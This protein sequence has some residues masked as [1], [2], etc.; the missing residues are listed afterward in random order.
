MWMLCGFC[1]TCPLAGEGDD[2][3][4]AAS[5]CSSIFVSESFAAKIPA[6]FARD[7]LKCNWEWSSIGT[8][9][10][11]A[12]RFIQSNEVSELISGAELTL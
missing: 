10:P 9:R 2:M 1:A 6:E 12:R 5:S 7:R 11:A 4:P 8:L 3:K